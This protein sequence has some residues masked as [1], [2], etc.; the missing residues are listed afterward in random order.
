MRCIY[1]LVMDRD[2]IGKK[3][4]DM[5]VKKLKRKY[6]FIVGGEYRDSFVEWAVNNTEI[7]KRKAEQIIKDGLSLNNLLPREWIRLPA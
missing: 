1:C 7:G 6:P 4:S 2:S 5:A 3:I